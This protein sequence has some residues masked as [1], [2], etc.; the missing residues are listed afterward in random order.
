V[1]PLVY[2][3]VRDLPGVP[4]EVLD[5]LHHER[6]QCVA[7]NVLLLAELERLAELFHQAGIRVIVLK[8]AALLTTE[9]ASLTERPL[10]DIDL[11][12]GPDDAAKSRQILLNAGYWTT[13]DFVEGFTEAHLGERAYYRDGARRLV[14]DLHWHLLNHQGHDA[15][16]REALARARPLRLQSSQAWILTPEDELMHLALHLV[17]HHGGLGLLWRRDLAMLL[18]R[19][20]LDWDRLLGIAR[21]LGVSGSLRM[22]MDLAAPLGGVVPEAA[23]RHLDALPTSLGERVFLALITDPRYYRSVIVLRAWLAIRDWRARLHFLRWKLSP[24]QGFAPEA[25]A[26]GR[27]LSRWEAIRRVCLAAAF[28]V[29]A[30]GRVLG[31]LFSRALPTPSGF[32]SFDD[33]R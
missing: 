26:G 33:R 13:P 8:G 5:A 9:R 14:V 16:E 1:A 32:Q 12:V 28:F 15:W 29:R 6:N 7:R 31:A 19:G 18:D 4:A 11:L 17:C 2:A 30:T 20:E 22:A 3:R 24:H 21:Q 25:E 23:R 10:T 27:R